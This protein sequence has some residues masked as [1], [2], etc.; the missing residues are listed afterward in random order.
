MV[1][2]RMLMDSAR[3]RRSCR[4]FFFLW[5]VLSSTTR[6]DQSSNTTTPQKIRTGGDVCL[7]LGKQYESAHIERTKQIKHTGDI[8]HHIRLGAYGNMG[9]ARRPWPKKI[10]T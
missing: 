9:T 5:M 1:R 6:S 10:L 8:R 4:K 7:R 3:G 2:C